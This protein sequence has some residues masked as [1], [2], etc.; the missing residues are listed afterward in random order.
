ME[1]HQTP[2]GWLEVIAWIS[3][4]VAFL[5]CGFIVFDVFVRRRRQ[6]MAVMDVVYPV[7][8]L[9]WGPVA[10]WFYLRHGRAAPRGAPVPARRPPGPGAMTARVQ[11]AEAERDEDEDADGT[12]DVEWP[13]VARGVSHCGAGCTLGD[14]GGEWLVFA[15]GLTI[16]G[17]AIY[18]DFVFD[19]ALAWTLGVAFQYFSIVP[20]RDLS[21]GAGLRAAVPADTLSI[22]AFQIGLFAGMAAYQLLIFQPPL[23]KTTASYWFLMQVSMVIG[24]FTAYPVNRWLIAVG[25]K[26]RM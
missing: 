7:T 14:I 25:W 13:Q 19:F 6:E 8:A 21:P 24:F 10:L 18:M 17:H 22:V 16:A 12:G 3:L 20:M 2:P 9:Y 26:E 5:V 4:V 15:L 1:L 23:A 11:R